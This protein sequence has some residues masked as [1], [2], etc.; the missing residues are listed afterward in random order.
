MMSTPSTLAKVAAK[1]VGEILTR[2]KIGDAGRALIQ[3]DQPP[4]AAIAALLAGQQANEAVRLLAYAMPKRE[5]VFWAALCVRVIAGDK[6][7]ASVVA[8]EAW[9][10]D[11]SEEHRRKAEPPADALDG[12]AGWVAM[13]AF[14]SGGSLSPVDAPLVPPAEHLCAHAA[15]CAIMLAAVQ[16][17]PEKAAEKYSK[18]IELGLQVAAG[19]KQAG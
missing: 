13:A 6:T 15:A 10:K 2:F 12:A 19:T 14:W 16:T 5:A 7:P 9:I 1:Q 17:E 3:D 11:P 18:F 8:A 4:A